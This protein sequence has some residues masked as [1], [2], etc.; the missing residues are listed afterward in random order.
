MQRQSQRGIVLE[1]L[2]GGKVRIKVP[3]SSD[4][5]GCASDSCHEPFGDGS[6]ALVARNKIGAHVGQEVQVDYTSPS[7]NKAMAVLYMIP[8]A[9][10][11]IGAILGYNLELFGDRNA[12]TA[13]VSLVFLAGSFYGIHRYD[14]AKWAKDERL[15]PVVTRIIPTRVAPRANTRKGSAQCCQ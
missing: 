6:T 9:A 13:L 12:S 7:S 10:L 8:L 5:G 4:C 15:E 11:L 14:K 3:R 1:T 2:S